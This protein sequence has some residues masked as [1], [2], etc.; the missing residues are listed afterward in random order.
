MKKAKFLDFL[1]TADK[2]D[3]EV[4]QETFDF[5]AD[6]IDIKF[7]NSNKSADSQ[8][9]SFNDEDNEIS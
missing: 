5:D 3:E 7:N 1:E 9:I 6:D 4:R 8:F 2:I